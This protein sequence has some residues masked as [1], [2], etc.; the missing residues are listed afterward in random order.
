MSAFSGVFYFPSIFGQNCRKYLD[1]PPFT[2]V[3]LAVSPV[4]SPQ[5]ISGD[6]MEP[7]NNAAILILSECTI[8]KCELEATKLM[9]SYLTRM[10]YNTYIP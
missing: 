2:K 7:D 1:I 3:A 4:V 8:L 10:S 5:E 9:L 6:K